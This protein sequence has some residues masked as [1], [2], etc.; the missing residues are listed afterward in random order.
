MHFA[1]YTTKG[2]NPCSIAQSAI[3]AVRRA[4]RRTVLAVGIRDALQR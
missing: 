4:R 1:C 3:A 2:Y